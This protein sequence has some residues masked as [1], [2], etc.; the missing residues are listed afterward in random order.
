MP[1]PI[2]PITQRV[3]LWVGLGLGQTTLPHPLSR[4]HRRLKL[5]TMGLLIVL[6]SIYIHLAYLT[7]WSFFFFFNYLTIQS[8]IKICKVVNSCDARPSREI[9]TR[10]ARMRG[11]DEA[12]VSPPA[13]TVQVRGNPTMWAWHTSVLNDYLMFRYPSQCKSAFLDLHFS[14]LDAIFLLTLCVSPSKKRKKEN[15]KETM[16]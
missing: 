2:H 11:L 13:P 10:H 8:P 16:K 4:P 14:H 15:N 3:K 6:T 12:V 1:Q 9:K 7:S 5:G